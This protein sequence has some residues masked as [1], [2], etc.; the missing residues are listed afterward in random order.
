V[1]TLL[2]WSRNSR[3]GLAL[4]DSVELGDREA[5]ALLGTENQEVERFLF[6]NRKSGEGDARDREGKFCLGHGVGIARARQAL[7]L[8]LKPGILHGHTI[9]V[10]PFEGRFMSLVCKRRFFWTQILG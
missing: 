1:W 5:D 7:K 6:G 4:L 3:K 10:K 2:T 8:A 9:V